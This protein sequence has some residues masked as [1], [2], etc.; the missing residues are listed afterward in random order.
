[1]FRVDQVLEWEDTKYK[2]LPRGWSRF[3]REIE[4]FLHSIGLG[5]IMATYRGTFQNDYTEPK[6]ITVHRSRLTSSFRSLIHVVPVAVALLEIILNLNEYYL[7]NTFDNQSWYQLIAKAHEILIEA[8]LSSIVLSY[9]QLQLM[10]DNGL[11]FGAFLGG[12]QFLTISYLWSRE[13]WSSVFT[14][15]HTLRKRITFLLLMVACGIIAA[16]AGPSSATLLIPRLALWPGKSTYVLLNGTR[17][18]I[19]P[20]RLDHNSVPQNCFFVVQDETQE[21]PLCPGANWYNLLGSLESQLT[22]ID[23]AILAVSSVDYFW[24]T[25]G[26]GNEYTYG[27]VGNCPLD[28]SKS[29]SCGDVGPVTAISTAFNS[30]IDSLLDGEV[31]SFIDIYHSIDRGFYSAK[32]AVRCLTD[33]I[34]NE[35]DTSPLQ[36]P[37][38]FRTVNEYHDP[39]KTISVANASKTNLYSMPGNIS[40]FRLT[41]MNLPDELT[42][43]LI[44]GAV[45]LH[46]RDRMTNSSQDIATCALAAGW[47]T[48]AIATSLDDFDVYLSPIELPA[49]FRPFFDVDQ[50]YPLGSGQLKFRGPIYANVSGFAYPQRPIQISPEWL[51]Y[52]NPFSTLPDG[53]NKTVINA[54]MSLFQSDVSPFQVAAVLTYMLE[55]GLASS[56]WS[57][58]WQGRLFSNLS[59]GFN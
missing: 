2:R 42:G 3:C 9:V 52:I 54:Y 4:K 14:A 19:W 15:I 10:S 11:P 25:A 45:L 26:P 55:G 59:L 39:G 40:D 8:S 33:T 35:N 34:E 16:T 53:T 22:Y 38:L 5:I 51:V 21:D 20:T 7:G 23:P 24:N 6:K 17:E 30:T 29:Q 58:P 44:S 37:H 43:G 32:T 27:A 49:S 47:G 12:L 48:S 56:G 28:K 57:V 36:F 31:S 13:L 41:W 18:D 1:M 50:T 46:P